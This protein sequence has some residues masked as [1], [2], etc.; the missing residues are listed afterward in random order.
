MWIPLPEGL[1]DFLRMVGFTW[2]EADEEKLWECG[3]AWG[4]FAT[5]LRDL[6]KHAKRLC[7]AS[8]TIIRMIRSRRSRIG[9]RCTPTIQDG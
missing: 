6:T 9:G 8:S 5:E 1:A 2:P 3:D 4:A 7:R